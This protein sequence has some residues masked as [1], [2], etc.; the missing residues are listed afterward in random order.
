[1]NVE[2]AKKQWEVGIVE[3]DYI[4]FLKE[5][6]LS[7]IML[8][9]DTQS[10]NALVAYAGFL[11]N[12]GIN[13]DS[14]PLYLEV[15]ASNNATAVD[16]LLEGHE[17]D[18]YLD[19][20]VANHFIIESLFEFLE[21][22]KRNAVYGRVLEVIIGF[23]VKVYRSTAEG[24]ALYKPTIANVN[25]LGKFLD[26]SKDQDDPLNRVILDV[27]HYLAELDTPH[28]TDSAKLAVARQSSRIRSD[29]FDNSHSLI[30]SMTAVTLAEAE[31]PTFGI[32]PDHVYGK[33]V[34]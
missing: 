4:R 14:Y 18:K 10:V 16:V 11:N 28:E 23:T 26:E 5:A 12:L 15:I 25:S 2:W 8:G 34:T 32:K 31:N 27:L 33:I 24:Y 1:M 21:T 17:P 19:C 3:P 29:F 7:D 13:S 20:V 6:Y 22:Q 30:E 9:S